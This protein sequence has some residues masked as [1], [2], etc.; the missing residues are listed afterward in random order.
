MAAAAAAYR[1]VRPDVELS[2]AARPLAAFNDQP[3]WDIEPGFDLVF[4]D[5]PT[6][7]AVAARS[8]LVPLDTVLPDDVLDTIHTESV[9]GGLYDWGGHRWA[10]G[11][12][13][14]CQ[15][16]AYRAD[17]LDA[18]PV[19]WAEVLELARSRPGTV[20]LPLYPSDAI[21]SLMTVSAN[22]CLAEGEPPDWLHPRG[23][24]FLAELA[25]LVAPMSFD[26]NPPALLDAMR[27]PDSEIAYV[28]L[29]FGYANLS[30]PPLR[31]ADI[32]GVT[33]TPHGAVL[34]GAGLGVLPDSAHVAEAA[35]FAAWCMGTPVQRDVLL[36]AGGQ[37]GNRLVWTDESADPVAGGFLSATGRSIFSAY[38]RPRD[39]WWPDLQRD[40]GLLL[41]GLLREGTTG[42]RIVKELTALA[43]EVAR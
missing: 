3:V 42:P 37:P 23:A 28:P 17:R 14:A 4:V 41:A 19:S 31:F 22:A 21:C 27:G 18:V 12:D 29:T 15:V 5:H 24:E 13:A 38:V 7:G 16:A 25:G 30:R 39:P 34:G 1:A 2:W 9:S 33:G 35:A 6:V 8:A 11:V 20:A 10:F 43:E 36:P 40:C 26:A 32:P